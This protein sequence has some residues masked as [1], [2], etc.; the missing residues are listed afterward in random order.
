MPH[1]YDQ[2][3]AKSREDSG[4]SSFS[5]Q[6]LLLKKNSTFFQKFIFVF[7]LSKSRCVQV[8]LSCSHVF[9][10]QCF[11]SYESFTKVSNRF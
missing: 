1:L 7:K 10:H 11:A 4:I 8:L 5:L 6:N 2:L 3:F 9:H